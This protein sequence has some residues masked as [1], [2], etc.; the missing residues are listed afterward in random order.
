MITMDILRIGG[1]HVAKFGKKVKILEFMRYLGEI[2]RR[3]FT[4][5]MIRARDFP[6]VRH[7]GG[8]IFL[9][10][11]HHWRKELLSLGDK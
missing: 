3:L 1:N 11:F 2:A 7:P 9:L 5:S 10:H 6:S 4:S 8:M